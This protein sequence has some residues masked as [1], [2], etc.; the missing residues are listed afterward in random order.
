[1][2][3]KERVA[4][5]GQPRTTKQNDLSTS[6]NLF[7]PSL[8]IILVVVKLMCVQ[9]PWA[10]CYPFL[11]FDQCQDYCH[12]CYVKGILG[13][14]GTLPLSMYLLGTCSQRLCLGKRL[15]SE[16]CD[17][18]YRN[19]WTVKEY[20]SL[21]IHTGHSLWGITIMPLIRDYNSDSNIYGLKGH[22]TFMSVCN[23]EASWRG[24]FGHGW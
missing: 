16:W 14:G 10:L 6:K 18:Y 17:R 13:R 24:T 7:R 22:S 11:A 23:S 2:K 19:P 12:R 1:V 20:C 9:W 3:Y 8:E 4:S 21:F 15:I 5:V